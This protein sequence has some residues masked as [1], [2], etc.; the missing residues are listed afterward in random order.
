MG[1]RWVRSTFCGSGACAEV[2]WKT[3]TFCADKSCAE[4]S[5]QHRVWKI[6][7]NQDPDG[8]VVTFTE[9]EWTAFVAGVK[10][11]QFD[12]PTA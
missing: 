10:D 6:R 1:D 5:H 8:P 11:G 3:S 12:P 7:N 2:K 9:D 4:V